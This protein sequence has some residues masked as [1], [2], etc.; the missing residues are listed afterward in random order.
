MLS[1]VSA[2]SQDRLD[3]SRVDR[4]VAA[5][6]RSAGSAP[7]SDVPLSTIQK[8]ASKAEQR[9]QFLRYLGIFNLV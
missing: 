8:L 2:L 3:Q 9:A 6:V 4:H 1:L 7:P 5:V